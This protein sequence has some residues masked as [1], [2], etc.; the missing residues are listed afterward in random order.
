MQDQ[1][2]YFQGNLPNTSFVGTTAV[3][4]G[5]GLIGIAIGSGAYGTNSFGGASAPDVVGMTRVD[6]A[7]GMF[8]ALVAAHFNH[9]GY[10][11]LAN[12]TSGHPND[13]W[14]WAAQLSLSIKNLPT[15]P[16]DV[17]NVQ[18]AYAS[19]AS[20]YVFQSLAAQNYAMF[21]GTGIPGVYQSVGF[22]VTGDAV[23]GGTSSANGTALQLIDTYGMRGAF[24]HNWDAQWASSIVGAW[25]ATSYNGTAKGLICTNIIPLLTAGSTCNP[26]FQI[27]QLGTGGYWTPVKGFTFS[28][29]LVYTR[30][31]QKHSGVL[32]APAIPQSKPAALYELKDQGT[33]SFMARAQR[34]L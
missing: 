32:A 10:Y 13:K 15:G 5:N 9:A 1:Y 18:G 25:A 33:F 29:Q 4:P 22:A 8:Q 16:R 2:A 30:V 7:W 21:G 11:N 31:D 34:N 27:W 6:Q 23:F 28:T 12:E 20:R 14:G 24:F 3:I 19:G 17:I 26:D